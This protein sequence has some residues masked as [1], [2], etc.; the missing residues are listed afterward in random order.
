MTELEEQVKYWQD[1]MDRSWYLLSPSTQTILKGT[2]DS[3]RRLQDYELPP[4]WEK[5]AE[6]DEVGFVVTRAGVY[7][8]RLAGGKLIVE[9]KMPLEEERGRIRMVVVK[10]DSGKRVYIDGDSITEEEAQEIIIKLTKTWGTDFDIRRLKDMVL[11][12]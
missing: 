6:L 8:A 3:L 2:L 4:K 1:I 9:M 5:V 7:R 11:E 10:L 12:M